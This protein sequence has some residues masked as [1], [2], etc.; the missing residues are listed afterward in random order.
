MQLGVLGTGD[1][2]RA[3]ASAWQAA[4]HDVVV[5]TRDPGATR[6]RG[7]WPDHLAL[8]TFADA[9]AGAEVVV[10][11]VSGDRTLEALELAGHLTGKVLVDVSNPLDFS[12]G[13]PPSLLVEDTDSLAEQVQRAHPGARVVKALNTV[14]NALMVAPDRL[15]EDTTVF[16]AGDDADARTVVVGL[17]RDLGWRDVIE[18]PALEAARGLEMWM[19][20]WLR[21]VQRLGSAQ[22]NLRIV[23]SAD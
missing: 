11:A 9:A 17:L 15:P 6:T 1:V 21:L 5:G 10:N 18:F 20:L 4:G 8:A 13:F 22:F 2:G 14:N 3:L 16:V 19:P 23:R 7:D 12:Q